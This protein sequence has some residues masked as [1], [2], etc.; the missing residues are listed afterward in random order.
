MKIAINDSAVHFRIFLSIIFFTM[1][2]LL[3]VVSW[4]GFNYV[5]DSA[6]DVRSVVEV[7]ATNDAKLSNLK[8]EIRDMEKYQEEAI[9]AK[10]V[11]AESRQYQYQNDIIADLSRYAKASGLQVLSYDF[12]NTTEASGTSSSSAV[13]T[14]STTSSVAGLKT[15]KVSVSFKNP[16]MFTDLMKFLQSV[17][18]N[19]MRMQVASVALSRP[20]GEE[21]AAGTVGSDALTIEVYIR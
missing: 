1:I 8:Q 10:N 6:K 13:T 7:A 3:A 18:S 11:V 2:S 21:A 9:L 5:S 12:E 20:T 4:L 14:P 17:E 16:V 15:T 19:N